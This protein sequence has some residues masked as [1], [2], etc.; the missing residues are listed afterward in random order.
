M[1]FNLQ[2]VAMI[3]GMNARN[4]RVRESVQRLALTGTDPFGN[5]RRIW[6]WEHPTEGMTYSMASKN[7]TP[8][9][10]EHAAK[11]PTKWSESATRQIKEVFT[12]YNY[13]KFA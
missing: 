3:Q 4:K 12:K 1:S 6:V 2:A 10:I 11:L 5:S 13:V 8:L 7:G 9:Y